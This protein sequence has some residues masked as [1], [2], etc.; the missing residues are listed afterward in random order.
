MKLY[1]PGTNADIPLLN[2]Y[3]QLGASQDLQKLLGPSVWPMAAFMRHF[4]DPNVL[5][6][7]LEDER[8]WYAV[9]W[10]FPMLGGGTWGL[11]VREDR[12]PTGNRAIVDFIMTSLSIAFEHF[13]VLVNT[14]KQ[15]SMV[16]KT[17]RLGYTYLGKIPVLFEGEDCHVL[18]QTREN[19]E[20]I[21]LRWRQRYERRQDKRSR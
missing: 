8:G 17:Q 18:Y 11:W 20:P 21:S 9:A 2:W 5:V 15:E 12:R 3:A 13:P 16:A 6:M 19:F 10:T 14:T 7:Y 1:I 4:T